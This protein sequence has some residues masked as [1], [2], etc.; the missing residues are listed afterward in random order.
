MENDV[1]NEVESREPRTL[2]F[3]FYP[4]L[5]CVED[6]RKYLKPILPQSTRHILIKT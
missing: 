4:F 3:T 2:G 6:L 1:A 5:D